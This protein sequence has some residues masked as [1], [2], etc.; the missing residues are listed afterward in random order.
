VSAKGPDHKLDAGFWQITIFFA[1]LS[2]LG[3]WGVV[4]FPIPKYL[5]EGAGIAVE[6]DWLFKF[7]AFFSVPILVFVNGYLL[8]FIIRY[9]NRPGQ[10]L[11]EA[12]SP[13]HDHP[14]LEFW[15][16]AIPTAL[17]LVLGLLS[18]ALIPQY[19]TARAATTDSVAVEAIGHQFGWEFRYPGLRDPVPDELHLPVDRAVTIEITSIDV[20]HSFWVPAFRLKQDM[21]PGMVIPI[22]LTPTQIGKYEI[23]CTEFCGVG[24]SGMRDR[25]VYVQSP[26][27][28]D[29]WYAHEKL[30]QAR[31]PAEITA[32]VLSAGSAASGKALFDQ[33]C[34]VC[35]NAAPFDRRKV[36]PGLGD[37]FADPQHPELLNGTAPTPIDVAKIL[38]HGLTGPMGTM[39]NEQMNG[40][41]SSD[42]A[43]LVAYLKTGPG[44]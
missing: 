31:A 38:E 14:A 11:E 42:I 34:I 29:A 25:Y 9:R 33:K 40:L 37:L 18:Y 1:V 39:P 12:G 41:S 28:F 16:T 23:I 35:H 17:M 36:G 21:V 26:A 15:W 13:I 19:Y 7:M 27:D 22:T 4:V 10:P 5:P 6:I 32:A 44:K 20:I 2:A 24:H 30:L 3:M 8:Y 43:D